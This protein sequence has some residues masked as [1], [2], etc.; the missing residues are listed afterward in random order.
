MYDLN[1]F[2]PND[3]DANWIESLPRAEV[4]DVNAIAQPQPRFQNPR[5]S[6][7]SPPPLQ[8]RVGT[9]VSVS[10]PVTSP[11]LNQQ[12][13]QN[14]LTEQRQ[15]IASLRTENS[16]LQTSLARL[17]EIQAGERSIS[18]PDLPF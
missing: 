18:I 6:P 4:P 1:R 5:P 9:P 13:L 7:K 12:D 14:R 17:D 11:L 15:V 3:T 16:T 10:Q 8:E 2:G